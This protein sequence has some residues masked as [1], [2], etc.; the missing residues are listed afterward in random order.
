MNQ[1]KNDIRQFVIDTFLFG[2]DDAKLSN[3]D[4]FIEQGLIDSM[5]I[6]NLVSFVETKYAIEVADTDLVPEI[7]DS[8]NRIANFVAAKEAE[9]TVPANTA[10][11]G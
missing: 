8:V 3:D 6:L 7:W 11:V 9:T 1:I 5:G 2:N 10:Y 4:S